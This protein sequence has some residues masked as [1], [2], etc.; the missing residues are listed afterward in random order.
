MNLD[1]PRLFRF[2]CLSVFLCYLVAQN[3]PYH[4]AVADE[5]A[6]PSKTEAFVSVT[7]PGAK[8]ERLVG[9]LGFAEGPAVD[10]KGSVYFSDSP[11]GVIYKR[12]ASG[13]VSVFREIPGGSNG[14]YFDADGSL[15]VCEV[16]ARRI[17]RILPDGQYEVV[18]ERCE[19]KRFNQPNDLWIDSKGGIYFT[20]PVYNAVPNREMPGEDV[21]Y[22][23]PGTREVMRVATGLTRPNGVVGYGKKLYIADEA[24]K[25]I[26]LFDIMPDGTLSRKRVFINRGSDGMAVDQY[27]NL[28]VTG[29]EG[30][31]VYHPT[32]QLLETIAV[33]GGATN[34]TLDPRD[35]KT[36]YI[37]APN[38]LYSIALR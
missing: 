20:D 13:A 14:L 22:I 7:A 38:A 10:K 25:V 28:Y 17:S 18:A 24:A 34:V 5:L 6:P 2:A 9:D 16:G 19:G 4:V 27:G 30:V 35:Y 23:K 36:L 33:P 26:Y 37:T 8:L 21:Y 15:Y 11:K 31:S 3:S 32:A 29:P 1:I 12:D